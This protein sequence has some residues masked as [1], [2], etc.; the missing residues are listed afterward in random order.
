MQI[1]CYSP[2]I[3]IVADVLG[4]PHFLAGAAQADNYGLTS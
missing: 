2:I 1:D 3:F 4:T